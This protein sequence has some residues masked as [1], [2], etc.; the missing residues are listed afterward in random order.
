MDLLT[1]TEL[2]IAQLVTDGYQDKQI[3]ALIGVSYDAARQRL[4][5]LSHKISAHNRAM[6]AA[7]YARNEE[8]RGI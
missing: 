5:I 2:R 7:W 1:P 4:C 6:V 3:A 8:K